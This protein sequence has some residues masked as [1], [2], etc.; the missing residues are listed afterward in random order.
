[1]G[2]AAAT[3]H[4]FRNAAA[5]LSAVSFLRSLSFA[6]EQPLRAAATI[7]GAGFICLQNRFHCG[8]VSSQFSTNN[9]DWVVAD[10]CVYIDELC[11]VYACIFA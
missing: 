1:M 4:S 10:F 2:T 11:V 6:S 8:H 7:P 9:L 5:G 3:S